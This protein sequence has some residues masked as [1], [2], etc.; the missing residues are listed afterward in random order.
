MTQKEITIEALKRYPVTKPMNY[1]HEG[2][3]MGFIKGAMWMQELMKT[4]PQ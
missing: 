3:R 1:L 4:P 2:K